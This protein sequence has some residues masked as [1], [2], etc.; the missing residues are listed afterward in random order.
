MRNDKPSPLRAPRL[1]AIGALVAAAWLAA[2]CVTTPA[3]TPSPENVAL[4]RRARAAEERGD[5][6]S[7][8]QLYRQLADA[9]AGAARAG[10]LIDAARAALAAGDSARALQWVTEAEGTADG[11]QRQ[12]IAVLL[13]ELD[14]R[15]E[16]PADALARLDR[17]GRPASIPLMTDAESVRGRALFALGRPSE[18][19]RTLV[20]RETWLD[21][22]AAVRDNQRMIWEGLGSS[23]DADIRPTGDELIDGWLALAPVA[24]SGVSGAALRGALVDW[25]REHGSHPAAMGLLADLLAADQGDGAYPPQ[26]ALLLPIS[27]PQRT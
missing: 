8:M 1:R 14:L 21:S 4:E 9:T 2:A 23:A 22:S 6:A 27:S 19:V 26:I 16:R 5:A 24:A 3:T 18:A 11:T 25:R 17:L 7:A 20:E 15:D 13:A 10:Y 12:A